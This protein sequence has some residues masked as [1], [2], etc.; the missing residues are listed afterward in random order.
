M[1]DAQRDDRPGEYRW[2]PLRKFRDFIPCTTPQT[3]ADALSSSAIAA[4]T[5]NPL[6]FAGVL[7]TRQ[8]ISA[9]SRP[10]FTIVMT[11]GGD[12]AI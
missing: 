5:R 7:Q 10:K 1:A 12:I 2:C 3:L 6:K 11:C 8:Q 9:A 4:K